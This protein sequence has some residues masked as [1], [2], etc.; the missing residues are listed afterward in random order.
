MKKSG[1]VYV[2]LPPSIHVCRRLTRQ[3][4]PLDPLRGWC[5]PELMVTPV[6]SAKAL[7][8]AS[9]RGPEAIAPLIDA[10]VNKVAPKRDMTCLLSC[11]HGLVEM[12]GFSSA[13][14]EPCMHL[15]LAGAVLTPAA[16]HEY[17]PPPCSMA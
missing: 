14:R 11:L 13:M 1:P 10:M 7:E 16:A 8:E 12:T 6:Y 4:G 17:P 2:V 9:H 5:S 15:C 3:L